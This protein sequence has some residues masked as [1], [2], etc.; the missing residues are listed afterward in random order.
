MSAKQV[1]VN[2]DHHIPSES[3]F[4]KGE[5][6]KIGKS[7]EAKLH[8]KVSLDFRDFLDDN[9]GLTI[10]DRLRKPEFQRPT[11]CWENEK[12]INLLKALQNNRVIPG[13]IF[14]LNTSTGHIFVLD[15]AHRLSAIRAW[16]LDDWGDSKKATKHSYLEADEK[17]AAGRLRD[18]V[19][20]EIGSYNEC[21]RAGKLYR[22][23]VDSRKDPFQVLGEPTAIKGKFSY[24][25][26]TSLNIPI[27]WVVGDYKVAEESFLNINTGGTPLD[28]QGVDFLTNRRSP[29]ARGIAG[30]IANGYKQTVWIDNI[31]ECN[32]V[33]KNLYNTLLSDSDNH[34]GENVTYMPFVKLQKKHGFYKHI[35]L[36]N[37]FAI[38]IH[39]KTGENLLKSTLS[40][41]SNEK[42]EIVVSQKT[43]DAL[44]NL[45]G[46]INHIR[47]KLPQSLGL[48]P[49]LYFYSS[50]GKYREQMLLMFL[51]WFTKGE[52]SEIKKRKQIF[53][54]YRQEFEKCWL[55]ARDYIFSSMNRKGIGPRRLTDVSLEVLDKFLDSVIKGTSSGKDPIET[56][57]VF[58]QDYFE[59][60]Y[61][62]FCQ[63]IENEGQ[64]Y[65][66]FTSSVKNKI[67]IRTMIDSQL[68]CEICGGIV[69]VGNSHQVDHKEE[70]AQGG[71]N[72]V[73]NARITHPYC[74]K[75][76]NILE[77][78]TCIDRKKIKNNN[79]VKQTDVESQSPTTV[80]MIEQ[81]SLKIE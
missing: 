26:S 16:F 72:G 44:K 19:S 68:K 59:P 18:L 60:M 61:S 15:G 2:L 35:F 56:I 24:N 58:L 67:E 30:I 78:N 39:K 27:Q 48:Y 23:A 55:V 66:A 32:E 57:K 37:L 33:S 46:V 53:S 31:E 49:P 28:N 5:Y 25:L 75:N 64:R 69:D 20:M 10:W 50:E 13:V 12:Y 79:V 6:D 81:L 77:N 76:R 38:S 45:E 1:N 47:G 21:I 34:I 73:T 22:D 74:N 71:T 41:L 4:T 52:E 62:T 51:A 65:K 70:R 54:L 43:F 17:L 36:L 14:W 9:S 3:L 42:N 29:V 80:D 7:D 63:D 8:Q 40:D 11:F